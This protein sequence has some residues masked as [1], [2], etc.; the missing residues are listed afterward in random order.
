MATKKQKN[1]KNN[2]LKQQKTVQIKH[3]F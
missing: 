1:A 3:V 2:V